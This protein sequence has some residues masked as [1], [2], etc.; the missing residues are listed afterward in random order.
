M[1]KI[2]LI[3]DDVLRIDWF[4]RELGIGNELTVAID[5]DQAI[6][7]FNPPYDVMF[8]DH[9]LGGRQMV[10]STDINTGYQFAKHIVNDPLLKMLTKSTPI[11]I[12]SL[13]VFG[14]GNIFSLFEDHEYEEVHILPYHNL[15][16]LW[17][18]GAIEIVGMKNKGVA[19]E[20]DAEDY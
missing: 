10:D 15:K 6:E 9:D 8:F 2:F 5:I 18:D 13:N 1:K 14:A 11:L 3:E 12:H 16:T 7:R 20:L 17:A 4:K 19:N